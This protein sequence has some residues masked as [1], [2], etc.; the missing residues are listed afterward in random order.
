MSINQ[1][2]APQITIQ[3]DAGRFYIESDVV[4]KVTDA[5]LP[6][7]I[8]SQDHVGGYTAYGDI[9]ARSTYRLSTRHRPS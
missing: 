3:C 9:T 4:R 1:A 2:A 5:D 6:D 7:T 8:V